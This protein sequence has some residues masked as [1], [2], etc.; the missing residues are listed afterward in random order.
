LGHD[1]TSGNT[2]TKKQ[3]L[4]LLLLLLL[5]ARLLKPYIDYV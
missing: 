4:L 2:T 3:H 1:A 5:D